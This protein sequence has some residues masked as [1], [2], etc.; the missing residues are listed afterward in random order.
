M[1]SVPTHLSTLAHE[2]QLACYG[3]QLLVW[4]CNLSSGKWG[5]YSWP[6][7]Q[8]VGII[9]LDKLRRT[10]LPNKL[11]PWAYKLVHVQPRQSNINV[12]RSLSWFLDFFILTPWSK[13]WG[14]RGEVIIYSLS[15]FLSSQQ[16]GAGPAHWLFFW[17]LES[18]QETQ[19]SLSRTHINA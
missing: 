18:Y 14:P 3:Q 12:W 2:Y 13:R 15:L 9:S 4:S 19:V 5:M 8:S 10:Q 17:Q 16:R 11:N 1:Q 7:L 6:E